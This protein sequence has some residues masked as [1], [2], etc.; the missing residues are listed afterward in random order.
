MDVS[1]K[2]VTKMVTTKLVADGTFSD[3][4]KFM[5]K[6]DTKRTSRLSG[7]FVVPEFPEFQAK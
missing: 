6:S 3:N 4:W 5:R 1:Q 2:L 7:S